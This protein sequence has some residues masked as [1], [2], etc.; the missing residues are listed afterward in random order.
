MVATLPRVT[1]S[2]RLGLIS[3]S[4]SF[5]RTIGGSVASTAGTALTH[6]VDTIRSRII[7]TGTRMGEAWTGPVRREG[8][9]GALLKGLGSNMMCVAP[10]GAINLFV[11]GFFVYE[12]MKENFG[13]A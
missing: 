3:S 1:T 12:L 6:P 10:Y 2:L 13:I 11:L 4:S 9:P 5:E 8:V 7:N